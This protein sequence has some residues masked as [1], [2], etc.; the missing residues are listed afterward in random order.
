MYK[1]YFTRQAKKDADLINKSNLKNKVEGLLR[2]IS[3]N[4]YSYPPEFEVLKGDLTG[5]ISRRINK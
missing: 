1:L 2:L 5:A 3:E 4:P